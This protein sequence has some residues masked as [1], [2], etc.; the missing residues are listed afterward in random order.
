MSRVSKKTTRPLLKNPD[1]RGVMLDLI[2][3]RYPTYATANI[4]VPSRDVSKDER[5]ISTKTE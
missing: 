4:E 2:E 5:V 1:P 3:K